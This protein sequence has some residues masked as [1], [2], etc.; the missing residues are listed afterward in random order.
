MVLIGIRLGLT[1]LRQLTVLQMAV[2]TIIYRKSR[3]ISFEKPFNN[4]FIF[5][6]NSFPIFFV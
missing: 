6:F 1:A 5:P 4:V 2:N 3:R